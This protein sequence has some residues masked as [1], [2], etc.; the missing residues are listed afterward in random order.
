[1]KHLLLLAAC[2][3]ACRTVIKKETIQMNWT[4][5]D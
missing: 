2:I 3:V 5:F 4:E 1:M